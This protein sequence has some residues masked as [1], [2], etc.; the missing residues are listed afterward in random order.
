MI[1]IG[2]ITRNRPVYLDATLRSLSGSSLPVNV[3][4][5]IYDDASDDLAA[6]RYLNTND[7]W[8]VEHAWPKWLAWQTAG[9]GFLTDNPTITGIAERVPVVPIAETSVGIGNAQ[10]YAVRDLMRR[11]PDSEAVILLEDDVVFNPDWYERLIAQIG[12]ALVRGGK[13]GLVAGFKV[14]GDLSWTKTLLQRFV[15][16]QCVLLRRT[17][18][19]QFE[20]WFDRTDHSTQNN[21]VEL[22]EQV[23]RVGY[24]IQLLVP[25]VG[26]HIGVVSQVRPELSFYDPANTG[27]RFGKHAAPPYAWAETVRAFP[28]LT[29]VNYA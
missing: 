13:Q 6:R 17:L 23:R 18:F 5:V 22:C 19:E 8:Q 20:P 28:P 14:G 3:P 25:Y 10:A 27:T 29:E 26:Q 11:F 12:K 7:T 1:P 24:E 16:T 15:S 2:I 9:L 4:L 21:D